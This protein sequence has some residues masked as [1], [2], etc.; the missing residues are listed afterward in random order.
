MEAVQ[1]LI[2]SYKIDMI[3]VVEVRVKQNSA[4]NPYTLEELNRAI[5]FISDLDLLNGVRVSLIME[6][7]ASDTPE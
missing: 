1:P 4:F 5:A 6:L 7:I 2:L 3:S